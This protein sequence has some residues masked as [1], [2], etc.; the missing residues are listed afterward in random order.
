MASR[1]TLDWLK[2]EARSDFAK[3]AKIAGIKD[4]NGKN[5]QSE[6]ICLKSPPHRE[7]VLGRFGSGVFHFCSDLCITVRCYVW[8]NYDE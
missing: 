1:K 4:K 8:E 7:R 2:N 3:V 5:L 6:D